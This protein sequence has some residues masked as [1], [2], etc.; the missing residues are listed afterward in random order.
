[1]AFKA[2]LVRYFI[3]ACLSFSII[4]LFFYLSPHNFTPY[5]SNKW[6]LSMILIAIDG[7]NFRLFLYQTNQYG[8][9]GPLIKYCL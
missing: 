6:K 7:H 8:K 1:M 2:D 5:Q 3:I 9:S 4:N